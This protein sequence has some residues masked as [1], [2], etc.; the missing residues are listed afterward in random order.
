MAVVIRHRR[1]GRRNR[2]CYR[3]TVA[4]S[5]FPRDGRNVEN[6][7]LYDPLAGDPAR[8]VA[9]NTERA[10]Y[11]FSKGAK[12]SETVM[13]IFKRAGVFEGEHALPVKKRVTRVGR[14]NKPARG[15]VRLE[16]TAGREERKAT[17]YKARVAEKRKPATAAAAG[18]E[19][20]ES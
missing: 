12:P 3:I 18:S 9:F 15:K 7:G 1:T 16:A 11:W 17:R 19:S 14:R 20:S 2:P 8:Q 6:L 10:R 5:R 4:D 13:S